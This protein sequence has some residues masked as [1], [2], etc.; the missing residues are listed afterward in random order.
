[1]TSPLVAHPAAELSVR[2]IEAADESVLLRWR[3]SS[4]S[5]QFG[6]RPTQIDPEDHHRWFAR[7]LTGDLRRVFIAHLGDEPIGM[8]RYDLYPPGP[9]I[10]IYFLPQFRGRGHGRSA[11]LA[12]VSE[13]LLEARSQVITARARL[14][15]ERSAAFF[16]GLGFRCVATTDHYLLEFQRPEVPHSR[17]SISD[18]EVEGAAA[19][20][21]SGHLAQGPRV[22]ELERQWAE[23]TGNS[24]SVAVSS[25]VAALR[26]ALLALDVG[27]DEEVIV[28]TY[29]CV[30]LLN[31]VLALGGVPRLADVLQDDWTLD[32]A[33]VERLQGPRTR[34]IIAVHLFGYP[35]KMKRLLSFG[36]P[37]VEDCAHGI[38]GHTHEGSAYGG[39]GSISIASF[40]ATKML[41]GGE[42]G[43]I[44]A[45][46]AKLLDRVRQAREYG[47]QPPDG[48]HLNDKMTDVEAAIILA[49]L[50]RLPD[51]LNQRRER[52]ARYTDQLQSLAKQGLLVLPSDVPGRI[53]YRYAV[54]LTQSFAHELVKSLRDYGISCE[55]PVWDLRAAVSDA[56]APVSGLGFDR[57]LSLPLYPGLT[58]L[59]QQWVVTALQRCLQHKQ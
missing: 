43:M 3:Q 21:R 19:V 25:G 54:R 50:S 42:G 56:D 11:F 48:R 39:A 29:S 9:E 31:A 37:V 40:Y 46:D 49:Q 47:D 45:N 52:A 32:P 6:L 2:P 57:V 30:A 17:P 5:M 23:A 26:L 55:Q 59:E 28:P 10:S 36:V 53:W 44:A 20:V 22:A 12:T 7:S 38:G 4:D 27:P 41:C 14:D 33:D 51:M 18:A 24:G 34:A 58:G 15:N 35:A 13:V 16:R 8:L 1:M